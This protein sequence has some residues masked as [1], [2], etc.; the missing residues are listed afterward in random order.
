MYICAHVHVHM[1]MYTCYMFN[2]F[3]Q[4]TQSITGIHFSRYIHS[5]SVV[6]SID[7]IYTQNNTC[8]ITQYDAHTKINRNPLYL[9]AG[10]QSLSEGSSS[11]EG[12]GGGC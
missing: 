7:L 8:A 2:I 12:V 6:Y 5:Y 1:Y 11:G 10:S 9:V 4:Y 3:F